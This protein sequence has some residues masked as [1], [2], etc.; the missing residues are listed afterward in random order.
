R[1]ITS[2]VDSG[3]NRLDPAMPRFVMAARD[4]EHL[5]AYL[6]CLEDD[7]DPGLLPDTVRVGTLQPATGPLAEL[8]KTVT[9]ILRGTF[10]AV[11]AGGGVHGR[12]IELVVAD[13]GA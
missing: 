5:T 4:V 7:G 12:R 1:A 10:D 13:P 11:N 2:G 9:A 6:K 3:G 8:G